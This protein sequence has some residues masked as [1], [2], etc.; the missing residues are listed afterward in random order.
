MKI[1]LVEV[2]LAKV[3]VEAQHS[4]HWVL[5]GKCWNEANVIWNVWK[6]LILKNNA[7]INDNSPKYKQNQNENW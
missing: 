6:H 7:L 2:K 3:E 1:V 4:E 5:I